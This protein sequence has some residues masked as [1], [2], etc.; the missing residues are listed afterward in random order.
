ML[1]LKKTP[2]R[3]RLLFQDKYYMMNLNEYKGWRD[4]HDR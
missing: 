4:V 1:F 3:K 2:L